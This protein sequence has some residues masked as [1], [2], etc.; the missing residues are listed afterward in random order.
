MVSKAGCILSPL[1]LVMAG[2]SHL[3]LGQGADEALGTR[4]RP[5]AS[6]RGAVRRV[7]DVETGQDVTGKRSSWTAATR[8]GVG[9]RRGRGD[10]RPAVP[11]A[12]GGDR[13]TVPRPRGIRYMKDTSAFCWD[14]PGRM[15]VIHFATVGWDGATNDDDV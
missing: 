3:L 14:E 12:L 11:A 4:G 15:K 1:L 6:A 9:R 2:A 13:T 8:D 5:T 10:R 7:V